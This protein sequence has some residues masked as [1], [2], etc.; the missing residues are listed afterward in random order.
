MVRVGPLAVIRLARAPMPGFGQERSS[1]RAIRK[2]RLQIRNPTL[3]PIAAAHNDLFMGYVSFA[4]SK[5]KQ[6]VGAN[7][8]A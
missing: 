5:L 4:I 7:F 2:V 1:T 6:L 3:D 8:A